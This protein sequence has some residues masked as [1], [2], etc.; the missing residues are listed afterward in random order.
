MHSEAKQTKTSEFGAKKGFLQGHARDGGSG[1][2]KPLSFQFL[3]S[4]F[5]GQVKERV[6][7][8]WSAHTILWLVDGEVIGLC[9]RN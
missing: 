6:Q 1:P 9:Y 8:L 2:R 3:Q 5:K 4:I 7:D